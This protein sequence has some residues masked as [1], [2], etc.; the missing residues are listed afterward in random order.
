M[1]AMRACAFSPSYPWGLAVRC[2]R[3]RAR[4]NR[5]P[6]DDALRV[7][8]IS[9]SRRA[10]ALGLAAS[11]LP[12]TAAEAAAWPPSGLGTTA[13]A[14]VTGPD[15]GRGMGKFSAEELVALDEWS[16]TAEG[17]LLSNGMRV[18]D[19]VEGVGPQPKVGDKVFCHF[20]VW[21]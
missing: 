6:L 14:V 4:A 2:A 5:A 11:A 16:K 20:K 19:V 18:I 12:A 10:V 13:A 3:A 21:S 7:S 8:P 15:R 17:T 9:P 1:F